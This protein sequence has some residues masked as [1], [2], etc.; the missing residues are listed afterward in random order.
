MLIGVFSVSLGV[1]SFILK[2]ETM[3]ISQP[4]LSMSA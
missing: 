1:T 3:D 2:N 4:Y